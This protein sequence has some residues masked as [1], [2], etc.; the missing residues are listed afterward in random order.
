MQ[1]TPVESSISI[2]LVEDDIV[3]V[4][5]VLR[6]FSL[7]KAPI[8]IYTA[9]DG[10][11]ALDLLYGRNGIKKI[12]R[13]KAIILDTNMPKMNGVEFLITLRNDS[14]SDDIHIFMLTGE[15]STREQLAT[16]NL[17]VTDR[18]IKPLRLDDARHI[19]WVILG[20]PMHLTM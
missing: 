14:N 12:P 9:K 20:R 13:P 15:Y 19:Y 6:Q 17:S 8:N 11:E 2:L 5:D 3:D 18:I 16:K 10:V 7:I 4:R 1:K